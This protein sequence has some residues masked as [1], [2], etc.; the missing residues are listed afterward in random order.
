MTRPSHSPS[1]DHP[2]ILLSHITN[3]FI[4]ATLFVATLASFSIN[5]ASNLQNVFLIVPAHNLM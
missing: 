4:N 5:L 2:N 3:E 1:S